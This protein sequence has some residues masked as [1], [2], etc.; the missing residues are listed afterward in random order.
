MMVGLLLETVRSWHGGDVASEV[1]ASE[2]NTGLP[3]HPQI[4]YDFGE[5]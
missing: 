4:E 2:S 3:T 1:S 5:K